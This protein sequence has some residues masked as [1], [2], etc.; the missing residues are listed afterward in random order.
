VDPLHPRHTAQPYGAVNPP[1]V[2]SST[3]VFPDAATGAARFAG[4]EAGLIYSRLGNPTVRS[5]ETYLA[6]LEGAED[7]VALASGMAAIHAVFMGHLGPGKRLVA[8]DCVYGCTHSLIEQMARWGVE[9][10]WVDSTKPDELRA[11]IADGVDIVFLETPMNPTTR[12][13]DIEQAARWT[14]ES[15]GLLMVDNTFATPICQRPLEFGADIVVHSLTKA[16]N[17]HSDVLGGAVVSS[18]E[19]LGPVR[20]WQKD[21]G[22]IMDAE[23]ASQILRGARTLR[24]RVESMNGHAATMAAALEADGYQVGH[25]SL[26][27]HPDFAMAQRQMPGGCCVMT[28]DVETAEAAMAVVNSLQVFQNAVSL[29]GYESLASHPASTTHACLGPDAQA[30]AGITPGMV[31]FSVGLDSF[32]DMMADLRQALPAIPLMSS[33]A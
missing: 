29:G 13:V 24:V 3:F 6:E 23:T 21:A 15:G 28:I 27:S 8:D 30:R 4:A 11:A 1:I 16:I 26:A 5:L 20:L 31:R 25:P 19:L 9:V 2:R 22:G 12:I 18:T 14:H 17:G 10:T 7:A 33:T 32:D